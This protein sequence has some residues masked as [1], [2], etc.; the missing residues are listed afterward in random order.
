MGKNAGNAL[1]YKN[2][3][4]DPEDVRRVQDL[5]RNFQPKSLRNFPANPDVKQLLDRQLGLVDD[6]TD[7]YLVLRIGSSL[8]RIN[9]TEDGDFVQIPGDTMTGQLGSSLAPGTSPFAVTSTTV[10]ANLNADLVDG[11]H[12]DQSLLTTDTPEFPSIKLSGL[13]PSRLLRL[14]ATG[15]A[16]SVIAL[17]VWIAGTASQVIVADDGDGSVTLSLPQSIGTGSSPEFVGLTL[18]GLTASRLIATDGVKALESVAAL[19]SWMAGTAN[20]ITVTDDGDGT[21][22][23][24]TPQNIHTGASPEF[25]GL[26]LSGLTASR[27]MATD[28]AKAAASVADLTNW[29]AGT[30]GQ[31]TVTDDGDGTVTLAFDAGRILTVSRYTTTQVLDANDH[32]VAGDTD[33]GAF[34][35]TLPAG[36]AGTE[37]RIANTGTSNNLL[38]IAPDGAELLLGANSN[39]I[40]FDG[41][42][43]HVVYETTEGWV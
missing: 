2:T 6:G 27:L 14:G 15:I 40:L 35:I 17:S 7:R 13:T 32:Q 24:S 22:T 16:A 23:L 42:A 11:F 5:V 12:H 3:D 25:A 10:N 41:E 36:V 43:L 1:I 26:T 21:V 34:T 37:Y 8:F 4:A 20:Q 33:G 19:T 31:V 38:T 9:M 18:S 28:G 30:T 29:I 39:F